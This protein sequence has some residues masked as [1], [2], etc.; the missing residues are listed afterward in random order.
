MVNECS[1]YWHTWKPINGRAV[2]SV[3][4]DKYP[5]TPAG[6]HPSALADK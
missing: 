4:A 3:L 2:M 5:S 6:K 1:I